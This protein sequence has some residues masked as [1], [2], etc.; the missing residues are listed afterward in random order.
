MNFF[1]DLG[2]GLLMSLGLWAILL[3]LWV[4]LS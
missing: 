4:V 1:R 3:G 2:Y